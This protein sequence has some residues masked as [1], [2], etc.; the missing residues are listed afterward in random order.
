MEFEKQ[1]RIALAPCSGG[2]PLR[3]TVMDR[4]SAA[5]W[6]AS[7]GRRKPSRVILLGTILAVAAAA[8]MLVGRQASCHPA[9]ARCTD[10]ESAVCT[11]S[12]ANDSAPVPQVG[13][14]TG[15]DRLQRRARQPQKRRSEPG[16]CAAD[17]VTVT[18]RVMPLQN[19]ATSRRRALRL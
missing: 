4:V 5:A 1:L 2:A 18:V 13:N 11:P 10:P 17:Q 14:G 8:A 7:Q 12:P 16:D 19:R 9:G 15:A 6:R 3:A